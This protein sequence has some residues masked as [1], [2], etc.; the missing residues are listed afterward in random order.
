[1]PRESDEHGTKIGKHAD[2]GMGPK[3]GR[4]ESGPGGLPQNQG[5]IARERHQDP[6]EFWSVQP[7]TQ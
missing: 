7:G 6:K 4:V 3:P 1:M 5:Q 2:P